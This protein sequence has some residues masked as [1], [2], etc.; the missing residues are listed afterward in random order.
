MNTTVQ[1]SAAD[2]VKTA[3][4]KIDQKLMN[5]FPASKHPH[6]LNNSGKGLEF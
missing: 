3:T 5:I 4:N 1:G 2:I 6:T